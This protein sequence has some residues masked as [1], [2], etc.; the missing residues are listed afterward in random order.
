MSDRSS[1]P[2]ATATHR[3]TVHAESA[4]SSKPSQAI[5]SSPGEVRPEQ[6]PFSHASATLLWVLG[7][8]LPAITLLLEVTSHMCAEAG[9]FDPIPTWWHVGLIALVPVANFLVWLAI[10]RERISWYRPLVYLNTVAIGVSGVYAAV[11]LPLTPFSIIG[12]VFILG[13]LALAPM[14]SFIMSIKARGALRRAAAGRVPL[15]SMWPGLLVGIAALVLPEVHQFATRQMLAVAASDDAAVSRHG[16]ALLRTFGSRHGLLRECYHTRD[17]WQFMDEFMGNAVGLRGIPR[18]SRTPMEVA[19]N[20]YYRVTGEAF[21]TVPAPSA[22]STGVRG[23]GLWSDDSALG[24]SQVA[25]KVAGLSMTSSRLDG[26]INATSATSYVEWTMV[27]KNIARNQGEARAQIELPPGGVVSRLTLWIDGEPREAAF[28][29]RAQV[30]EAYQEVAVRQRR[31]PVLVTTAGPDRVLMQCFPVPP[32]GGEMKIRVGITAPL[33]MANDREGAAI[34]PRLLETNFEQSAGFQHQ[35]WLESDQPLNAGGTTVRQTLSEDALR[36]VAPLVTRL[37][38]PLGEQW[39]EDPTDPQFAIRQTARRLPAAPPSRVAFV[40]DGSKSMAAEMRGLAEA[41]RAR[42]AGIDYA[43]IFASDEL[44]TFEPGR[45]GADPE[46]WL[47]TREPRGGRDS[48]PALE[49]A[50]DFAAKKG[51]GAIVWLHGPQP[52]LM[53]STE[54]LLQRT[55][56]EHTAPLLYDL[57]SG[58]APNRILEKLD[59]FRGIRPV[60]AGRNLP[61]S[62]THLFAVWQGTAPEMTLVRERISR[63]DAPATITPGDRHIARLWAAGEVERL[64]GST[65]SGTRDLAMKLA[66][67]LQL[68]TPV[69]GAVVLER[70]E[71]YDRHGLTPAD[72]NSVP[73][74]PEPGTALLAAIG[75]AMLLLRRRRS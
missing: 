33:R 13:W 70:Q 26:K 61:G 14:F 69:S 48:V 21:N 19:Q 29:G 6:P 45:D 75:G 50:W 16:V 32:N 40:I 44:E 55:E 68:V 52:V 66:V 25:G 15:P 3:A 71:Q 17:W 49:R 72:V 59:S 9:L 22:V 43:F 34:L 30:R 54:G 8:I 12:L 63:A 10:R 23:R 57:A 36:G 11:F 5:A 58:A 67:Q 38:A 64:I 56:R 53:S 4:S 20:V 28:G 18:A 1:R 27:F 73:M 2:S 24:G 74:I 46:A 35:L 42:P 41:L 31:D 39:T 7:I 37:P 51:G 60:R 65:A 47:R 62:L